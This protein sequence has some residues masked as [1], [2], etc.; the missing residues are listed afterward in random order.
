MLNLDRIKFAFRQ[1]PFLGRSS[2]M[3]PPPICCAPD[4]CE[5]YSKQKNSAALFLPCR[6]A[7]IKH[8]FAYP[9]LQLLVVCILITERQ[10]NMGSV[11]TPRLRS[12]TLK[13]PAFRSGNTHSVFCIQCQL[14]TTTLSFVSV[15]QNTTQFSGTILAS[16]CFAHERD[17]CT[18]YS[19][20]FLSTKPKKESG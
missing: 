18:F 9:C 5:Q 3:I 1:V 19:S 7:N 2:F 11:I 15:R 14:S 12:F 17:F 20:K 16:G 4:T 6:A 13:L 8:V 10:I